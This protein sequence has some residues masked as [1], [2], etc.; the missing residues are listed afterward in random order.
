MKKYIISIFAFVFFSS[1][2]YA[3]DNSETKPLRWTYSRHALDMLR[4]RDIS[5]EDVAN[6]IHRGFMLI[7]RYGKRA[8]VWHENYTTIRVVMDL[9]HP[10]VITVMKEKTSF[11]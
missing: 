9:N 8:F 3:A 7:D 5:K 6:A 4:E 10:H 1:L 2:S 11:K